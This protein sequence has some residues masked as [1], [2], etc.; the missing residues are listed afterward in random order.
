MRK[1]TVGDAGATTDIG[2]KGSEGATVDRGVVE[3]K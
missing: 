2:A 1:W 3:T